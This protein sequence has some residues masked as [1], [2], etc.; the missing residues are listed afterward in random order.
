[1]VI[2]TP[3]TANFYCPI[4]Y[5]NLYTHFSPCKNKPENDRIEHLEEGFILDLLKSLRVQRLNVYGFFFRFHYLL[6]YQTLNP[7]FIFTEN[8]RQ[9]KD[10]ASIRERLDINVV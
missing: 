5:L 8:L 6:A 4:A 3:Q 7:R 1:M 9:E 2:F 10:V